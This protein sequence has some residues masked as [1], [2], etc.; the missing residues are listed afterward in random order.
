MDDDVDLRERLFHNLVR[1]Y[2]I[3][4]LLSLMLCVISYI[5]LCA[6]KRRPDRDE[7]S[8]ASE[9][10]VVYRVT[11]LSCTFTL[12]VSIGAVMLL[13]LSIVAN[14]AILR[15]P[16]S[17]YLQWVNLS[18]IHGL[19][20][21]IFISSNLSLFVFMPFAYFF[22]ESEGLPGSRRGIMPRVY[23]TALVFVLFCVAVCGLVWV[24]LALTSGDNNKFMFEI[25]LDVKNFYLLYLYSCVSFIGVAMLLIFTPIGFIRL[26]TVIGELITNPDNL[27][28]NFEGD[29]MKCILE[30]ATEARRL[31]AYLKQN[32]WSELSTYPLRSATSITT[33]LATPETQHQHTP[34]SA[35]N[36][37]NTVKTSNMY[38]ARCLELEKQRRRM[39]F[40]RKFVY[41]LSMLALLI[42]M[43][44]SLLMVSLN[45]AELLITGK[46]FRGK[47]D[48]SVVLGVNSI[49]M[50]GPVGAA[51]EIVVIFYL[52]TTSIVGV[53]SL[54]GFKRLYP[55]RQDTPMTIIIANCVI[56]LVLSSALPVLSRT[57]GIS[58]F[59]LLGNF[60]Q[61]EWL[62]SSYTILIYNI[63]FVILTAICL[64][65]RLTISM[66]KIIFP[67]VKNIFTG[68]SIK[69]ENSSEVVPASAVAD[70]ATSP[71]LIKTD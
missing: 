67:E 68:S 19:W 46:V 3:S 31:E 51:V 34:T 21:T 63:I 26:F 35:S 7:Y 36:K 52:M 20:N 37:I 54:P 6:F 50:L 47:D 32:G 65:R 53:Y 5:I 4:L 9:D 15:F 59:D 27:Q 48:S 40:R 39:L 41:P 42:L 22:T 45:I 64:T 18:L 57:L 30:E 23:E 12:A 66:M 25:F 11:L 70:A 8:V 38:A 2:V 43:S 61:L 44:I 24:V 58:N 14:E 13:P 49:S 33:L 1:E 69:S 10:A 62:E 17:Y 56:I 29:I 71:T 28:T 16:N 60:G 55:K